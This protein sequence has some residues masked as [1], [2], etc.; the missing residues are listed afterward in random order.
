V[1]AAVSGQVPEV[2]VG[3]AQFI[4]GL[5]MGG[6]GALRLAAKYPEQ[7]RAVSAHSAIT[8]FDQLSSFVEEPLARY[9]AREDDTSVLATMLRNRFRLPPI[10]FDCGVADPLLEANRELHRSLSAVNIAH[11]YEEFPGGHEW[12]Y[13]ELHLED[14]LRFFA[15]WL[16]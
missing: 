1:P 5:S 7:Y 2:T 4:A 13:W 14:T 6:F 11:T 15:R 9:G 8:H 3:S 12:P 16:A 10:R